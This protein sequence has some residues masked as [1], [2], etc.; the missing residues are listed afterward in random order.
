MFAW[1]KYQDYKHIVGFIFEIFA[2]QPI[3]R[4]IVDVS[5]GKSLRLAR[6]DLAAQ[7]NIKKLQDLFS[8]CM[9]ETAILMAGRKPLSDEIQKIT[10]SLPA[11]GSPP[12]KTVLMKTLGHLNRLGLRIPNIYSP[13]QE[14]SGRPIGQHP[15]ELLSSTHCLTWTYRSQKHI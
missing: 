12:D 15:F 5:L 11:F 10:T 7:R 3:V 4:S 8:S 13:S 2:T 6:G 1:T 9:N 14:W